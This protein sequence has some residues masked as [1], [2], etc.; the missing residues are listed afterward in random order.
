M[1]GSSVGCKMFCW[2][3]KKIFSKVAQT[4]HMLLFIIHAFCS[5]GI[6]LKFSHEDNHDDKI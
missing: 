5:L 6:P 4:A 3:S 1:C 2:K